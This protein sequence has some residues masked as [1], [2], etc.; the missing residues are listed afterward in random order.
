[1]YSPIAATDFNLFFIKNSLKKYVI[2]NEK[3][4]IND[5][6]N[7]KNKNYI[8]F[9]YDGSIITSKPIFLTWH[10]LEIKK[11]N[12]LPKI[13]N[14]YPGNYNLFKKILIILFL[15]YKN[16]IKYLKSPRIYVKKLLNRIYN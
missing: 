1:M 11:I 7:D 15:F 2:I 14:Q 8:F 4:K 13:L 6:V 9:G 16:P 5:L 10:G 12:V 3:I